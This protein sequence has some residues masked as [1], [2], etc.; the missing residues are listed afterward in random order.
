LRERYHWTPPIT[1][2]TLFRDSMKWYDLNTRTLSYINR[3]QLTEG[4]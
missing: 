2:D 1:T 3:R 4:K